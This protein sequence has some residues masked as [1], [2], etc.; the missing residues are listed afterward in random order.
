MWRRGAT[1]LTTLGAVLLL[2]L[3]GAQASAADV[4]AP[5][6]ARA[7][8]VTAGVVR[9]DVDDFTFSRL[10][11]DYHLSRAEDGTSRLLVE[12][13][14]VA[15][16]PD[17]DQNRGMRR[18]IPDS[19]NGQPLFPELVSITDGAGE[20]RA[21]EAE[22]D[23]GVYVMTSRADSYVHGEQ[24]YVF[25]YE[26][27]N[28]TWWFGDTGADEFY[29][30]VN[31]LDWAQPFG[32]VT[33]TLH[34]EDDLAAALTGQLACYVGS[35]G[36]SDPCGIT[37]DGGTVSASATGLDPYQTMT[38]AVGFEPGT[39]TPFD[40]RYVASPGI[41]AQL[42]GGALVLGG[43][44]W[45]VLVRLRRLRD[46][47]G[48]PTVVAQYEPPAVDALTSAV[49]LGKTSKAVPAEVLEQ[50][51]V[52]SIRI[53]EGDRKFFGGM[54]LKAV[55]GDRSL[56]DRNGRALLDGLFGAGA[57]PGAE[58]D[59]GGSN[60]ALAKATQSI[61]SDASKSLTK[62]GLYRRVPAK[63]RVL[64]GLVVAAGAGLAVLGGILSIDAGSDAL[65]PV[66]LL[67][68][69]ALAFV[70]FFFVVGHR[71]RSRE[72][73]EL[74]DPLKG[75]QEF[76]EW[77][78]ADRIR[79]LQS[80]RGAERIDTTDAGQLLRIYE[81]LLPYAVVFGQ[82]KEWA[83]RL[84]VLYEDRDLTPGWYIGTGAFS[85]AAFSSG[86]ASL[87]TSAASS[88]STSGGSSGGGS[89]GGGGGG[90]GGGGV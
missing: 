32:E 9:A 68:L 76:I 70:L 51:V 23:D 55:L 13:R 50:A 75:R 59:F 31:G 27:Q 74:R 45:A 62:R 82:E 39:F 90:G 34:L 24:T 46:A 15:L 47:P 54:R 1:A 73:A 57:A 2:V 30:D 61:L 8:V 67:V 38:I 71:P 29:W 5:D 41:W 12:E 17:T 87:S 6:V 52:G 16:F 79:M 58:F 86:I 66:L 21:A 3:G 19:Y 42:P 37:A 20:P 22:S 64:P 26:L 18:I 83:Q 78:E 63:A 84:A 25:T 88:S 60:S 49:F 40:S 43:M 77:A 85:A 81:P 80:P 28:V 69:G 11:V 4:R 10:A 72:G 65:W 33:A 35:S 36:S 89:A 7:D 48:H 53:V 56:A 44:V 14:F